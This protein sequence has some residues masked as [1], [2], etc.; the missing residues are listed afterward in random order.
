MR[1]F[2]RGS[3]FGKYRIEKRLGEGAF[4]TVYQALD[5]LEGLRVALKVPHAEVLDPETEAAVLHEVRLA[6]RLRH[7]RLLPLKAADRIDGRIVLVYP[8]GE[9][10]LED[11]LRLRLGFAKALSYF[12]ALLEGVAAVH[13]HRVIHCD[14]KPENLIFVEGELLLADFGIAKIAT[15]TIRASGS[16]TVGYCAPEQAMGKPSFR[17]DVFSTGLVGYRMMAGA[18]PEWP[19]DWPPPGIKRL[20]THASQGLVDLLKRSIEL[21]PKKRFASGPAMLRA[22]ERI[23]VKERRR[24]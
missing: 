4:A 15:R 16:G 24:K 22:F 12:E 10:T 13:E 20:R 5:T 23:R 14:I 6:A 1:R 18:L 17:S 19:F 3:L 11:R 21:D 7:P 2:R 8:L 9:R